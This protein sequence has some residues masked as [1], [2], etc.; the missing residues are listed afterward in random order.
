MW[1]RVM[2]KRKPR[3]PMLS[4]LPTFAE[5]EEREILDT[6]QRWYD[7]RKTKLDSEDGHNVIRDN[8]LWQLER[9][10][11][12]SLPLACI[13]DMADREHPAADHA[14]RI[15]IHAAIDAD[16][17]ATL[18]VQ[19]RAYAQRALTR[20]PLPIGYPSNQPQ[21]V[22]DFTRDTAVGFF[23]DQILARWPQV[24]PL[25]STKTRHSAAWLVGVLFKLSEPQVRRILRGRPTLPRRLVEFLFGD[26]NEESFGE[27]PNDS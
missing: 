20:P 11:S 10:E 17:F 15:Y 5:A 4:T 16:R 12:A 1:G 7:R 13:I 14:L 23:Y 22:S 21:V 3:P 8:L 26:L 18:P 6:L 25:H 2:P 27:A 24:P 9:G 19:I